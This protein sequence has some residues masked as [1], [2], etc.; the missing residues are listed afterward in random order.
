MMEMQLWLLKNE[1]E[2]TAQDTPTLV[3]K[4]IVARHLALESRDKILESMAMSKRGS[5]PLEK[6]CRPK[7]VTQSIVFKVLGT[8]E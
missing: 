3:Y 4:K 5:A 1:L 2:P 8:Q 7:R 6:E